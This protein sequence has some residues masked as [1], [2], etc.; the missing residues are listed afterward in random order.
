M[1]A[2]GG[3]NYWTCAFGVF[4]ALDIEQAVIKFAALEAECLTAR[5]AVALITPAAGTTG[6]ATGVC[7]KD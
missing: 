1:L 6:S 4:T 3:P 7:N 5:N 2:P